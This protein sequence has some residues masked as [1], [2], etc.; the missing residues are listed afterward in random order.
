MIS[1]EAWDE[2]RRDYTTITETINGTRRMTTDLHFCPDSDTLYVTNQPP[3]RVTFPWFRL[4]NEMAA[5]FRTYPKVLAINH[6]FI[7]PGALQVTDFLRFSD[8]VELH[9]VVGRAAHKTRTRTLVPGQPVKFGRAFRG[10]GTRAEFLARVVNVE[11]LCAELVRRNTAIEAPIPVVKIM[12]LFD[13]DLDWLKP[14][15]E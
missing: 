14:S 1:G 13:G 2:I 6:D 15:L 5:T 8:M 4:L 12:M 10:E 3:Q 7:T 11:A 9:V